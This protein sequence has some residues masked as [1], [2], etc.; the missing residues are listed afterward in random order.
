MLVQ[1]V[2]SGCLHADIDDLAIVHAGDAV[3]VGKDAVVVG[4]DDHGAVGGAC[5]IAEKFE[6]DFAVLGIEG[7][8]G[9]VADDE[10]GFVDERA[11]DG[12]ALLL[13]AGEF[14]WVITP[15]RAESHRFQNGASFVE[16][17]AAR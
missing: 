9:F 17:L 16:G 10:W 15:T 8:G 5:D 3:G 13:T 7:G 14:V 2:G 6:Y 11:C 1:E 4:D 12:D